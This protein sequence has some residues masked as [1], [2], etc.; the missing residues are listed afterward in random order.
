M[1]GIMDIRPP[2]TTLPGSSTPGTTPRAQTAPRP[3]HIRG[4]DSLR[5]SSHCCVPLHPRRRTNPSLS[6]P[7]G[8]GLGRIIQFGL[9]FVPARSL[10]FTPLRHL[11][12]HPG[13]SLGSAHTRLTDLLQSAPTDTQGNPPCPHQF[14]PNH[15]FLPRR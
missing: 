14:S 13:Q 6:S 9:T 1:L 10:R 3:E 4:R 12:P 7:L 15:I 8:W 2:I 11:H 5:A